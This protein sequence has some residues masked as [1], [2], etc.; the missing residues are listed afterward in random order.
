MCLHLAATAAHQLQC[1]SPVQSLSHHPL[2]AGK[3]A[4]PGKALCRLMLS[5]Y[6][7]FP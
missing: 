6:V 2:L 3:L 7:I 1:K 4:M 5:L